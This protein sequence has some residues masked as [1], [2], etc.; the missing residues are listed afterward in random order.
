MLVERVEIRDPTSPCN[1]NIDAAF[2]EIVEGISAFMKGLRVAKRN[3]TIEHPLQNVDLN[4]AA[5]YAPSVDASSF[6]L[7][8]LEANETPGGLRQL[9]ESV[10]L[11]LAHNDLNVM[12]Q[13][14]SKN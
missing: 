10:E 9:Y 7:P 3:T 14:N 2:K 6:S 1:S 4:T 12:V 11:A 8:T 5:R 13:I